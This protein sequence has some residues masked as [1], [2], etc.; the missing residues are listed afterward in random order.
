MYL[1]MWSR[2]PPTAPPRLTDK[3]CAGSSLVR[4][5]RKAL[6]ACQRPARLLQLVNDQQQLPVLLR[7]GSGRWLLQHNREHAVMK[8]PED[9][10][11]PVPGAA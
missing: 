7:M 9:V 3:H 5:R 8:P 10:R 4:F 2:P 6:A 1:S 11:V